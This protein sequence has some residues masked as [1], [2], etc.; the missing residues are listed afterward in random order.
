MFGGRKSARPAASP[1]R[2][3]P[4]APA[5]P[6]KS[7]GM[8]GGGGGLGQTMATGMAFGAGSAIAHQA[9]GGLMGGRGGSEGGHTGDAP[10]Q[11]GVAPS[12]EVAYGSDQPMTQEAS[13]DNPCMSFNQAL[14]QCL[15]T[16]NESI[17]MCQTDMNMVVQCERD[18]ANVV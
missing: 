7:G 8:L 18:N 17:G 3:R 1:P 4:A 10:A 13:F 15:Q 14:L 6:Q 16:N 5:A 2:P 9:I 11:G 12:G